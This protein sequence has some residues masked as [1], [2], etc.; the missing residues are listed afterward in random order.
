M[1]RVL[2]AGG[3]GFMG[4]RIVRL[5][6]QT[7]PDVEVL[8]AGRGAAND[9]PLDVKEPDAAALEGVN[10]LIN[11]VGPFDYDPTRLVNASHGAGAHYVDI[12]ETED[13]IAKAA[14]AHDSL[15][16]VSGASSVPGLVQVLAQTCA[17]EP[18]KRIRAQL[19]IGTKNPASTTLLYSMLQQ[20][21]RDGCFRSS[22]L[23]AH[24]GIAARRYG[25]YPGLTASLRV[26][27]RDVPAE[28]G[29]GFDR[30]SYT[31][32]LLIFAPMI[33]L[34]PRPLLRFE[35][36]WAALV[37]PLLGPFGTKVGILSL[38]ALDESGAVTGSVEVRARE[39]GLDVP[40]WPAVWA[41]EALL[42]STQPARRLSDLL[43]PNATAE[44]L[45]AAGYEVS[46]T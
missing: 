46:G 21:G 23:R 16:A 35:A 33:G 15:A 14:R 38:D 42:K 12:A 13:F 27:G 26:G 43:T 37:S 25:S 32:L 10:V 8:T 39:N 18:P 34:L 30:R 2:V 29:F 3:R 22:W 11:A 40:A 5:L 36:W 6:K 9:R 24:D 41:T 28:F 20:V 19:S 1:S 17:A 4:R 44:K 7:L 31:R 45:R